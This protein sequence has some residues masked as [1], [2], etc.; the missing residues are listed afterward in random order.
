MSRLHAW[1]AVRA[2]EDHLRPAWVPA[3]R[4]RRLDPLA[5]LAAQ[6]VDGVLGDTPLP[7][8][9]ALVL[10][11][12][13]GSLV[14]TQRFADTMREFGD[15][16]ASPSP[17]TTSVHNATAGALGELLGLHGPCL[18]LSHG[19]GSG[20]AALLLAADLIRTG[21]CPEVLVVAADLVPAW[22]LPAVA[23]C[24]PAGLAGE[25]GAAA[26]RLAPTGPGLTVV[27][28]SPTPAPRILA[29]HEAGIRPPTAD[30]ATVEFAHLRLGTWWPTCLLAALP[31][32]DQPRRLIE[33][34]A[35]GTLAVDLHAA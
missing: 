29:C 32:D 16:G 11:T 6:A 3:S 4:R 2:G 18:T 24:A 7:A 15:G 13:Y 34:G 22:L 5:W 27:P 35:T 23:T 1:A 31:D 26:L 21:R 30:G 10:G 14:S 8:D 12:A 28:A 9:A 33:T 19:T 17:F 25:G 20:L